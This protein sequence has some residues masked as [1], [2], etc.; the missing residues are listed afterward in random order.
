[1]IYSD[2]LLHEREQLKAGML[3]QPLEEKL[4]YVIGFVNI[5]WLRKDLQNQQPGRIGRFS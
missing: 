2:V 4:D 1:M 5:R 3:M